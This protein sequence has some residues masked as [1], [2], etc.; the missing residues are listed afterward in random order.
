MTP[1]SVKMVFLAL[2]LLLISPTQQ[3]PELPFADSPDF[4]VDTRL[5]GQNPPYADSA[6][7]N[8]DTRLT[9]ATLSSSDSNSFNANF[10]RV[11]RA[12]ADADVTLDIPPL[13]ATLVVTPE[14]PTSFGSVGVGGAADRTFTVK[15]TGGSTLSGSAIVSPP[16]SIV[17]GGTYSL[18]PNQQQTVT[19]R[20]SPTAQ[21]SH[22]RTLYF[23]APSMTATRELSGTALATAPTYG[24]ITGFVARQDTG[25]PIQNA[26]ITGGG[27]LALSYGSGQYTIEG[28]APGAYTVHAVKINAPDRFES[29]SFPDVQVST[30]PPTPLDIIVSEQLLADLQPENVPV[31]LVKG[32]GKFTA[33]T[34]LT[35]DQYCDD[36]DNAYCYWSALRNRLRAQGFSQVWDCNEPD[37]A[38]GL[39]GNIINGELSI[40]AN[41]DSLDFYIYKKI[42]R[43]KELNG[44]RAP[45]SIN[46][47]AHSMG[48][49]ITRQFL[50]EKRLTS[51]PIGSVIMLS[52]PNAGT[53]L[54][55]WD[56]CLT[57]YTPPAVDEWL[58]AN[59]QWAS[60]KNLRTRYV[61]NDFVK[62]FP[63]D[64]DLYL[65][66]GTSITSSGR[67]SLRLLGNILSSRSPI[68]DSVNDG[69]V[70]QLSASGEYYKL[71]VAFGIPRSIGIG[72]TSSFPAADKARERAIAPLDHADLRDHASVADWVIGRLRNGRNGNEYQPPSESAPEGQ[73]VTNAFPLEGMPQTFMQ[74]FHDL[75]G[76]VTAGGSTELVLTSDALSDLNFIVSWQ[77][78]SFSSAL[79]DPSNAVISPTS[80]QSEP[81]VVIYE[82]AMPSPGNWTAVLDASTA[83]SNINYSLTGFGDSS[84][85]LVPTTALRFSQGQEI[86]VTCG[87]ISDDGQVATPI[88]GASVEARIVAPDATET[89]LQL[90]DDGLHADDSA[91]DGIY[92]GL[93]TSA[94]QPGEYTAIYRATG[95]SPSQV[96][97]ARV[98]S[99]SFDL[100]EAIAFISCAPS[101]EA[102]DL[103][104]DGL[105]DI[106]RLSMCV[107]AEESGFYAISGE[108]FDDAHQ[109]ELVGSN[110]QMELPVGTSVVN[111]QFE[112]DSIGQAGTYGPF[113]LQN[114]QLFKQTNEGLT[115]L[116]S[117]HDVYTVQ[118]QL[119]VPPRITA[120]RS[121]RTHSGLGD[122]PIVLDADATGNGA[123][124]PTV[125]PREGGIQKIEIVFDAT[126]T[127]ASAS[128]IAVDGPGSPTFTAG[129][130]GSTLTIDFTGGMTDG[131][132]YTITL[133]P[134]TLTQT[135]SG[136]NDCMIRALAG[137][138]T[139]NGTVNLGDVLFTRSRLD[140]PAAVNPRHDINLSG[141]NIDAD[142]MLA[143]KD[144]ITTPPHQALC[145]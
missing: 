2:G 91:D 16:F 47:V 25:Q 95:M 65:L 85:A 6:N 73:W 54:A 128:N 1:H 129:T 70:T 113:A 141:G 59:C 99:G 43:Y 34:T 130:S 120:W 63:P 50:K 4:S 109:V 64:V 102:L 104:A 92:A 14:T 133:G 52:T 58:G 119:I 134:G 79:R 126:V 5:T 37:P 60:T 98:V 42:Q 103:N 118:T 115:W 11:N 32:R 20:Y 106:I 74:Q 121:V 132:C 135:L 111:I 8:L 31:V 123:N 140:Q 17:S 117:Y 75:S 122:L 138:T 18:G 112:R 41:A 28:L 19:V 7:F 55:D 72:R 10:T 71:V 30:G 22:T 39:Y 110:T 68:Q 145:P 49:L 12:W 48:G 66:G 9:G 56:V 107:T 116:D 57:L 26:Q 51:A 67:A 90:F 114:L 45:K 53:R 27:K 139:G 13:P 101:E 87:L 69:L 82:I 29:I 84:L 83:T 76:V 78:D 33:W 125:E 23:T 136:D 124:G 105:T 97:F 89:V 24:S 143:I 38:A 94:A 61:R 86:I 100:S 137:D 108:L 40:A 3:A 81:N 36:D 44:G 62:D 96:P 35:P 144:A 77:G 131:S 88:T 80:V 15:N 21:G 93:Y 142:D 127:L 46:I